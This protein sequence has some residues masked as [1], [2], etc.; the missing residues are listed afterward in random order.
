MN[1]FAQ[2]RQYVKTWILNDSEYILSGW[3]N[4]AEPVSG[5]LLTQLRAAHVRKATVIGLC[6][7]AFGLAE[8]G[9][10]DGRRATTHWARVEAFA[11]R[12]PSVRTDPKAIFVDEGHVPARFSGVATA[13]RVSRHLFVAPQC[14]AYQ[15]ELLERPAPVSSAQRRVAD[16]LERLR[17]EPVTHPSLD[18]LAANRV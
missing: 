9:L 10:L 3:R 8:A 16:V 13:N 11:A 1:R 7:G 6:L 15:P 17:A 18:T 12:F 2:R 14:A 4:A 5:S